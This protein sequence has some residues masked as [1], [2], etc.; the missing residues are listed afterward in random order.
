MPPEG[1]RRSS[2][3]PREIAIL[4]VGSDTEGKMFSEQTKTVL[5]SRYGA[6]L[7]S[8]YA[9]SAEQELIL[10]RLDT[11]KEAEVRVVGNLGAHGK[12][13]TYGVAFLNPE[14][15]L[16]D[17]K[18]PSMT[19]SEKEA[20]RVL[21]Q[22]SSCKAREMVE[23]SDLESDVYLVNEGIVRSCKTCGSSTIWKRAAEDA[24][25]EPVRIETTTTEA[26]ERAEPVETL[27]FSL[28]DP[29]PTEN[30]RKH[31]RTKVNFKACI[32]SHAFGDDVVT[33]E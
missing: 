31:V 4:L 17:I 12:S 18:F 14:T 13:Y 11:S 30:R 5:L 21:L 1:M 6:G 10:R 25:G 28:N 3:I 32:R 7:V 20:S 15:A 26:E 29:A 24:D 9:L 2:R 22:C 19:E 27:P 8:Q 23:Q 33:C 16:W